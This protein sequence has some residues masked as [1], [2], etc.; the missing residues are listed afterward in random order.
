M[1]SPCSPVLHT[2]GYISF[3]LSF[4]AP[5]FHPSM[6]SPIILSVL[7]DH[8]MLRK[9]FPL[10]LR[11]GIPYSSI[12]SHADILLF[13][14]K[15]TVRFLWG[16]DTSRP[17][18]LYPPAICPNEVCCQVLPWTSRSV[19][20]DLV[21]LKCR[22]CKH[23]LRFPKPEGLTSVSIKHGHKWYERSED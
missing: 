5:K 4:V 11:S 13:S 12:G 10:A 9:S 21:T 1:T 22:H 16:N 8:Y 15:K 2:S 3:V 14:M 7:Y 19:S 6:A 18:G 17:F 20:T 23:V